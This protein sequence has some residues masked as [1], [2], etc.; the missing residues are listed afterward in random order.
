MKKYTPDQIREFWAEQAG[1]YGQSPSASRSNHPVIDM[2]IREI[3]NQLE[4]GWR[5]GIGY[6]SANNYCK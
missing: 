2:E 6:R 1:K 3:S 5:A 4:D